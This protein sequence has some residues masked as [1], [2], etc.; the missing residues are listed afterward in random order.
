MHECTAL[1]SQ[2]GQVQLGA[3]QGTLSHPIPHIEV[4]STHFIIH[5]SP[6]YITLQVKSAVAL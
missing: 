1:L 6:N 5:D 3:V 4:D 2:Q